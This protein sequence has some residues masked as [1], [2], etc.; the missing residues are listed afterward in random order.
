MIFGLEFGDGSFFVVVTVL[1][2]VECLSRIP[3]FYPLDASNMPPLPVMTAK[4]I[5]RHCQ[6]SPGGH[7]YCLLKIPILEEILA[8]NGVHVFIISLYFSNFPRKNT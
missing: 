3:G 6:T 4:D 2:I 7:D 5:S 8:V 1:Y